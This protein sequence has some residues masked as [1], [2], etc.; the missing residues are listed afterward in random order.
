[1][2]GLFVDHLIAYPAVLGFIDCA[3]V[4]V[5]TRLNPL[6]SF[7]SIEAEADAVAGLSTV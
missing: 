2:S 5:E 7:G 1:M 3:H 4:I 6:K